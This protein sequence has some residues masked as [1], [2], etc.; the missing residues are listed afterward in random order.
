MPFKSSFFLLRVA[1]SYCIIFSYSNNLYSYLFNSKYY[2][3]SIAY[4]CFKFSTSFPL[5]TY[6]NFNTFLLKKIISTLILASLFYYLI[7][8]REWT[9]IVISQHIYLYMVIILEYRL[10]VY[11][12]PIANSKIL[13]HLLQVNPLFFL[14]FF[15]LILVFF[16]DYSYYL[17]DS[18]I[19]RPLL[20]K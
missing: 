15:S 20:F 14:I 7:Q 12:F 18:L 11:W 1:C 17:L 16:N 5:Y 13:T 4:F 8:I 6:S 2:F 10:W 19:H 3:S 9:I